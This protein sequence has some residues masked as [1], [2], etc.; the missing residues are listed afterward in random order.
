MGIRQ[1]AAPTYPVPAPASIDRRALE[2]YATW[3]FYERRILCQELFPG[4]KHADAFVS[5]GGAE[6]FHFGAFGEKPWHERP[7]PSSRAEDMLA[8][9][10]IDWTKHQQKALGPNLAVGL[11]PQPVEPGFPHPDA[12]LLA[13][14]RRHS[15]LCAELI[16]QIDHDQEADAVDREFQA[17]GREVCKSVARSMLGLQAKAQM[18]LRELGGGEPIGKKVPDDLDDLDRLAWSICSDLLGLTS[19]VQQAI[20]AMAE[21]RA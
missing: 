5:D 21:G 19:P 18:L 12:T 15:E 8:R 16:R 14:E 9:L 1:S 13:A 3:L 6:E 11:A 7:M 17:L 2:A 4:L 10:G 20:S